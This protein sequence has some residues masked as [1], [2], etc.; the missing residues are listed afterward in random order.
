MAQ[1][2]R[3]TRLKR[4]LLTLA[5]LASLAA[6]V[7]LRS[8]RVRAATDGAVRTESGLLEGVR[9]EDPSVRV[10]KGIPFGA[11]PVGALPWKAPQPV[12]PWTGVRKA[13]QF[14]PVC[15]Q[16]ARSGVS[17]LL[18]TAPRLT[19]PSEDCLYLNV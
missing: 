19:P 8:T 10:F 3:M 13:D 6:A 18:P 7:S 15:S 11:P 4:S 9:G 2:K 5:V 17:A 12:A 1:M 14:G 16:P